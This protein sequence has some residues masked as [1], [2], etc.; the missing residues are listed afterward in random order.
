MESLL[1]EAALEGII[2]C[3]EC[4]NSIEPDCEMCSCGWRNPLVDG[5]FI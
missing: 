5:G 2:C 1:E 4:G 3:K